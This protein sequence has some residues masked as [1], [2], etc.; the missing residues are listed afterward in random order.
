MDFSPDG[1]RLLVMKYVS[2]AESYPGAV[3]VATGK[4][5]LFPVD[6]GKASFNGFALRAGW[7]VGV[8]HLRRAAMTG[9]PQEFHTLRYHN[10]ATGKFEVLTAATPWDVEDLEIADDG[11]HLAYVT[12]EDGIYKLHVLSLPSHKP[13]QLPEL[14][15]G[16]VGQRRLLA[17][18]QAPGG[19]DELGD[20][21][22]RRLR[23]RPGAAP[24]SRAGRAA[25]S[26]GWTRRSSSRRRWCATRPSTRV[27]GTSRA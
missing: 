25:K 11:K 23:D 20:L 10:P 3:D 2:A 22:Q 16:V 13:V 19:D 17:G 15:V 21:A 12:N 1:K 5:E 4:L 8:L 7:P 6:G 26:A 14:P 18:R 27:D 24:S 9:K